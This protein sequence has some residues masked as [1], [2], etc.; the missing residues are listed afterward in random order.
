MSN[1]PH[2]SDRIDEVSD[3]YEP[4][5]KIDDVCRILFYLLVPL[6]LLVLFP[7]WFGELGELILKVAFLLL[8]VLLF[9]LFLVAK[10]YF[11][12]SAERLRRKQLLSD[13]F[14]TSLTPAVTKRYYN[15]SYEPSHQRLAANIMENAFFGSNITS[16]MLRRVR[17][18][19]GTYLLVWLG[20]LAFR[21]TSMDIVLW[22]TQLVFSVDIIAYWMC[23]E[24]LRV[25]HQ[26]VYDDLYQH[27]LHAHDQSTSIGIASI[28]DIFA[29]YESNK[30][31]AGVLLDSK[32]FNK[33]NPQ[34][35]GQWKVICGKIGI[36]LE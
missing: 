2:P 6:S 22:I 32:I 24:V 19:C 14:E 16:S 17:F 10:L 11:I 4:A 35:S 25:R 9:A 20:A 21:Q 33:E 26:R 30:A 15:N 1:V 3:A 5:K 18:R 23:L 36:P 13:A 31:I 12:P 34:L 8:T 28:L 27:F 7:K 29:T